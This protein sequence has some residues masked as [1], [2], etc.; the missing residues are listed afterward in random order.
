MLKL[1]SMQDLEQPA[2]RIYL[3]TPAADLRLGFD[4]LAELVRVHLREDP[5][6]GALF[7]FRSRCSTRL[8]IL[9]WDRDGYCLWYK[10]LEEGTFRF[11]R[12]AEAKLSLRGSDLA[13]LLEG[14]DLRSVKRLRRYQAAASAPGAAG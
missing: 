11:P 8:K 12:T 9:Y 7:L 13:M 14:I 1:P 3:Y 6:C 2:L 10:R 5:L 4:R